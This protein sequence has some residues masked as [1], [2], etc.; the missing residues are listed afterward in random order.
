MAEIAPGAG[1]PCLDDDCHSPETFSGLAPGDRLNP[2]TDSRIVGD[3]LSQL[4]ANH[5]LP[6]CGGQLCRLNN[7][8]SRETRAVANV[9]I[10]P[11]A[12]LLRTIATLAEVVQQLFKSSIQVS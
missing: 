5:D 2:T 12:L 7:R 8:G 9:S 4:G 3:R 6:A 10:A 11:P 1:A